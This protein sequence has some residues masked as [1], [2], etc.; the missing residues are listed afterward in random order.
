MADNYA[1]ASDRPGKTRVLPTQF[2]PA[3]RPQ[4]VIEEDHHAVIDCSAHGVRYVAP[5]G[6]SPTLGDHV[7]GLL[8]FRHGAQTPI[9]VIV[10]R[11]EENQIV[12]YIPEPEIPSPLLRSEERHLLKVTEDVVKPAARSAAYT[13]PDS[14][15]TTDSEEGAERRESHRIRYPMTGCPSLFLEGKKAFLVLDVSARGLRYAASKTPPPNLYQLVKGALRFR[16]GA[17]VTIEGTV[18]RA[19]DDEVALYLHQEVPFN[20][21]LAE[22]RQLHKNF[23]MWSP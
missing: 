10:M 1:D 11:V 20:I 8:R 22:Q 16:R 14:S 21:L 6:A 19:Q 17:Q 7:K 2:P 4:L 9:K 12:L 3:K 15:S 5:S 18:I 13:L 23:P